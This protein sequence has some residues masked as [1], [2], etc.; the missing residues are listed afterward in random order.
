M[1]NL[2]LQKGPCSFL[3]LHISPWEVLFPFLLCSS[4]I[5]SLS[6]P[7]GGSIQMLLFLSLSLL[8]FS[9]PSL[10]STGTGR[11][12]SGAGARSGD[13]R[14]LERRRSRNAAARCSFGQ[15]ASPR[16]RALE[17]AAARRARRRRA[18]GSCSKRRWWPERRTALERRC[19]HWCTRGSAGTSAQHGRSD[20]GRSHGAGAGRHSSRR[21]RAAREVR[22]SEAGLATARACECRCGA[23][24]RASGADG[25]SWHGARGACGARARP[26][27]AMARRRTNVGGGA[28]QYWWLGVDRQ[29]N[30]EA[31]V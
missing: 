20:A 10:P 26:R 31:P 7:T 27:Q 22:V 6:S 4:F 23:A 25:V 11:P 19:R 16:R 14:A 28:A 9:P 13:G 3:N 5:W 15:R 12:G 8:A 24:A 1:G 2:T 29:G 18:S 21:A 17:H 30:N